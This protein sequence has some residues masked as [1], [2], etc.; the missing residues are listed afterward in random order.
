MWKRL[1]GD[2]FGTSSQ[3]TPAEEFRLRLQNNEY[4]AAF[5]LAKENNFNTDVV[6][7]S[8][9]DWLGR[10]SIT[11]DSIKVSILVASQLKHTW[12]NRIFL[13][14]SKILIGLLE[15]AKILLVMI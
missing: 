12:F 4:W 11:K 13:E 5:K 9:K 15:Y 14:K 3:T 7:Q 6:Y 1:W 8:L 10:K 2:A